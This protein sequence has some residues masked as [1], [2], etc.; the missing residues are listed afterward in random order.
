M[1]RVTYSLPSELVDG[2][3]YLSARVGVSR[4]ALVGEFLSVP[5]HD[6]LLLVQDIPDNPT[7]QDVVRFRGRSVSL[8][9]S[10]VSQLRSMENDLFSK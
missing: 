7:E 3:S 1:S 2:I 5:V 10:R 6:L 9:E 4:S 8:V